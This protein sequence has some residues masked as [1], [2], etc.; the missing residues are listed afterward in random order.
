MGKLKT[1]MKD[2]IIELLSLLNISEDADLMNC[3]YEKLNK[4]IL[5][6]SSLKNLNYKYSLVGATATE[7]GNLLAGIMKTIEC[8]YKS[9]ELERAKEIENRFY[10]NNLCKKCTLD[11]CNLST[12]PFGKRNKIIYD[13]IEK[14]ENIKKD[15]LKNIPTDFLETKLLINKIT[16]KLNKLKHETGK[17]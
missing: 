5:E 14:H 6:E 15:I 3:L 17:H 10:E 13:V 1:K 4:L 11:N 8:S 12:C 16:N 2:K 7:K 9:I